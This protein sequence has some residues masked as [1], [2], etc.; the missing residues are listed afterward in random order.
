MEDHLVNEEED[1]AHEHIE[2]RELWNT[3]NEE[4]LEI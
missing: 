4:N 1:V 2:Q 3:E